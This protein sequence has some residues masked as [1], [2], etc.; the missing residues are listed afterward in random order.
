MHIQKR[1]GILTVV[2]AAFIA[3]TSLVFATP[4]CSPSDGLVTWLFYCNDLKFSSVDG[5]DPLNLYTTVVPLK[6]VFLGCSAL[7][8]VGILWLTNVLPFPSKRTPR[9]GAGSSKIRR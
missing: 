7:C 9:V 3:L 4:S 2:L 6:Y 5:P 8:I 1:I